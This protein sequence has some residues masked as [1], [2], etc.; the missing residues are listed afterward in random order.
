MKTKFPSERK[1]SGIKKL[2]FGTGSSRIRHWPER[3][4]MF[5]DHQGSRSKRQK[6][7]K[8]ILAGNSLRAEIQGNKKHVLFV[9]SA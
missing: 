5:L 3:K 6:K 9:R 2:Q 8:H 7:T 1:H 4:K